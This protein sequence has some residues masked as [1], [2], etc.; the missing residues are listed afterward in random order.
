MNGSFVTVLAV[1]GGAALASPL[2]GVISV[3]LPPSTLLL[4]VAVGMAGGILLGTLAFE[5]VPTALQTVPL[6]GVVLAVVIGVALCYGLDL[7][8]HRGRVAG[9]EAAEKADVDRF[10][11]RH[12]PLG[13][14]VTVLAVGTASEELIEGLTIGVGGSI[15]AGTA[16]V[17][18]VA[19]SIDNISEA[20]SLGALAQKENR[21][22]ARRRTLLWTSLI[23][24]SLFVSALGGWLLLRSI[25]PG[26]L[27][28]LLAV[29]AG[30]M[31]YLTVT[32][33]LPEADRHQFQQSAALAAGAGFLVALVLSEL[34]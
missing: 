29:G 13:T 31:F 22:T 6:P 4:S 3:L 16:L 28:F 2:G 19:I 1:A 34:S 7:L 15:G 30:A 27:G 14:V 25:D 18:G 11:R 5:M 33:L 24:V 21:K 9:E 20:L 10:H 32:D 23:G 17:M 8:I 12:R 26:V